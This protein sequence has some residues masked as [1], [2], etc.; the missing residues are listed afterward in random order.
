[1]NETIKKKYPVSRTCIQRTFMEKG[2]EYAIQLAKSNL[3]NVYHTLKWNE[4]HG[5][6]LYRMSSNMFPHCS[7]PKVIPDGEKYA[8]DIETFRE[9]CEKIGRF[10]KKYGHR[11]TFHP[12]QYNVV[13]TPKADA[14]SKTVIELSLHADILDMMGLDEDSIMVV[15]GGG[16]YG[17]K[18]D[19]MKR[20]V[21]QFRLLPENVQKRLVIEN[22]EKSYTA[23]DMIRLSDMT[24]CPVVFDTHHH[25]C[26]HLKEELPDPSTFLHDVLET[27]Y[28]RGIRPKFHISEQAVGKR[29][30]AHSDYVEEVPGYL[31]DLLQTE[32]IDIMIEAKKKELAVDRLLMKYGVFV[33]GEWCLKNDFVD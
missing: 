23:L 31:L 15:H 20:W 32:E 10:A 12:G 2:K 29:V 21:R 7:N 13:G 17:D 19:T 25:A 30:G 3:E 28:R 5:I 16:V 1:M 4:K 6:R 26:Y 11:L 8:Y 14:F 27:W 9:E 24:G 22:C 18:E 33:D